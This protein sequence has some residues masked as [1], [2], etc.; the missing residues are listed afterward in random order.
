MSL[1]RTAPGSS[2]RI[3]TTRMNYRQ[4]RLSVGLRN[5]QTPLGLRLA[6]DLSRSFCGLVVDFKDLLVAELDSAPHVVADM[7]QAS[8]L[9]NTPTCRRFAV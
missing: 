6:V 3:Y 2:P 8:D 9:Y 1:T 4:W 7:L 5:A